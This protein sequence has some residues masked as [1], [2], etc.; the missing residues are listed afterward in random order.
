MYESR[1]SDALVWQLRFHGVNRRVGRG[2]ASPEPCL[3]RVAETKDEGPLARKPAREA[4]FEGACSGEATPRPA[5]WK[6]AGL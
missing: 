2:V 6:I 1:M 4:P 5:R 3:L